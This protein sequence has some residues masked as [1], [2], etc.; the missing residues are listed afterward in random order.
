M[1]QKQ[2]QFRGIVS[3][4][5]LASVEGPVPILKENYGNPSF[6]SPHYCL[7]FQTRGLEDRSGQGETKFLLTENSVSHIFLMAIHMLK[8]IPSYHV[9][10]CMQPK[11][12]G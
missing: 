4:D 6:G 10:P 1:S 2:S 11:M 9:K 3:G 7:K 8:I 5:I 12:E